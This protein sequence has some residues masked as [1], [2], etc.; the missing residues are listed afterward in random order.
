MDTRWHPLLAEL[1]P[2][3]INIVDVTQ[4]VTTP[5]KPT[6]RSSS[7][8]KRPSP[9]SPSP[10]PTAAGEKCDTC[11][12]EV[13]DG[14]ILCP[15]YNTTAQSCG[16]VACLDCDLKNV[17]EEWLCITCKRNAKRQKTRDGKDG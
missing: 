13:T 4:E 6:S 16:K 2:P 5:L 11:K 8:N 9:A 1:H 3:R 15:G 17:E 10:S 7:R 12:V 14:G